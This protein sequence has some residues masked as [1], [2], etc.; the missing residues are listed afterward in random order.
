MSSPQ[1]ENNT[2]S[3]TFKPRAQLDHILLDADFFENPKILD[4]EI[5]HGDLAVLL[6]VKLLAA[7][8]RATNG[9]ISL[10]TAI[11]I[12]KRTALDREAVAAII[13]YCIERGILQPGAKES[14]TNVRVI[15]DQEALAETR[16]KWREKH[17]GPK[18]VPQVFPGESPEST[19]GNTR[20]SVNVHR[21]EILNTEDLNNN[22][23][24]VT[25][26]IFEVPEPLPGEFAS[27]PPHEALLR[28][29]KY[30]AE[31]KNKP[32]DPIQCEALLIR[33]IGR[34]EDFIKQVNRAVSSGWLN[35]Q[36]GAESSAGPP[37]AK[38]DEAE[39]AWQKVI[40]AA[41]K[42]GQSRKSEAFKAFDAKTAKIVNEVGWQR[43]CMS[44]Y[45]DFG[46]R[47]MFFSL[48]GQQ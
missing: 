37:K 16:R 46:L 9:E 43:I 18:V 5:E 36:E 38:A 28:W 34:A 22:K 41:A 42:H 26:K 44:K 48:W 27:G 30:R 17:Q 24:T 45:D 23:K 25:P 1:T 47:K 7:M 14:I 3:Q 12:G 6:L 2:Q 32:L 21:C 40:S 31:S 39:T 35:L 10:N 33:Y 4:L 29:L 20:N 13:N 19:Q 11:A 15:Q 8:S